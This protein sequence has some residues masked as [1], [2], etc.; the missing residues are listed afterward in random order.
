MHVYPRRT[1]V[2]YLKGLDSVKGYYFG[3]GKVEHEFCPNC[4]SSI[5]VDPHGASGD[6]M[7]SINVRMLEDV[8]LDQLKVGTVDGRRFGAPYDPK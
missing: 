8:E 3:G 6:D 7:V 5:S 1:D 2:I 4:G